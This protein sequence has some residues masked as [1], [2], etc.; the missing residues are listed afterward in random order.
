MRSTAETPKATAVPPGFS[1]GSSAPRGGGGMNNVGSAGTS[2][3]S[4]DARRMSVSDASM[5]E[6][7]EF[8][9]SC[10]MNNQKERNALLNA[11]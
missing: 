9:L 4:S 10:K 2:S 7:P 8:K 6:S 11:Y 1:K 3:L 5:A